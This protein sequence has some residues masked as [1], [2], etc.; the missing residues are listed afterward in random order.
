MPVGPPPIPFA[1]PFL[2][3]C[4]GG[5]LLLIPQRLKL[6]APSARRVQ[7]GK[8]R[9]VSVTMVVRPQRGRAPLVSRPAPSGPVSTPWEPQERNWE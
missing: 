6:N 4:E 9:F 2:A 7:V 3:V 8:W 1:V 5:G